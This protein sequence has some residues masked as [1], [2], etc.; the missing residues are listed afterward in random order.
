MAEVERLKREPVRFRCLGM[1]GSLFAL[2]IVLAL[3]LW[4]LFR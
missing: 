3:V 4:I 1:S 2:L